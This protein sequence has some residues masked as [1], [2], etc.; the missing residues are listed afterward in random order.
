MVGE[1]VR[2]LLTSDSDPGSCFLVIKCLNSFKLLTGLL[3]LFRYPYGCRYRPQ[4]LLSNCSIS[5]LYNLDAGMKVY[6]KD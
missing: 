2:L 6:S 3:N 1:S 5:K 4:Y